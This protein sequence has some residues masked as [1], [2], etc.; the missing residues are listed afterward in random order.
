ML[1]KDLENRTQDEDGNEVNK[2]IDTLERIANENELVF[3]DTCALF[4]QA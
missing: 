1:K 4:F 2:H 3:M